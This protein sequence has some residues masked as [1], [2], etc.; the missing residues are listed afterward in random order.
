M[1]KK[2]YTI[3][4]DTNITAIQNNHQTSAMSANTPAKSYISCNGASPVHWACFNGDV[5]ALEMLLHSQ[6]DDE[7]RDSVGRTA[8]FYAAS[9]GHINCCALLMDHHDDWIDV[10]DRKGDTPLHVAA[11]Y[12]H[13]GVVKLL[14][15]SAAD[16]N[17]R[18]RTGYAPLHLTSDPGCVDLLLKFG[19]DAMAVDKKGRT[20]LF[21]A[22]AENRT[23]CTRMFCDRAHQHPRL[24]SLADHRGDTPLHAAACN[25]YLRLVT[26]LIGTAVNVGAKN[27]RGLTAVELARHNSHPECV[28][29]LEPQ[30][31]RL[32]PRAAHKPQTPKGA[33]AMRVVYEEKA[34]ME[35]HPHAG[36]GGTSERGGH[37][38]T[39][40][41]MQVT[42]Q[43][44][45]T[46]YDASLDPGLARLLAAV[47]TPGRAGIGDGDT[48]ASGG[49]VTA[50][51]PLARLAAAVSGGG[52]GGG[53]AASNTRTMVSP[54]KQ[55]WV[56]CHD[57]ASGHVFFKELYS[58]H[59]QWDPPHGNALV[60][61]E[62]RYDP[63]HATTG[64]DVWWNIQSGVRQEAAPT[65]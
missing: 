54:D 60:N 9:N 6:R 18:N 25:G 3:K 50:S 38:G 28:A 22:C 63:S 37:D 16:V 26:M 24:I 64:R 65:R 23:E 30:M 14:L 61:N 29:V 10:G 17:V 11:F 43:S 57:E 13:T 7:I 52:G 56:S 36:W 39:Q 21:C 53:A 19:A 42:A 27:V 31:A 40:G 4:A 20:P 1:I 2:F 44:E 35:I 55:H 8:L 47:S 46:G 51:D 34:P 32:D 45:R 59:T 12:Q 33:A 49:G 15:E 5:G 62:W 48:N 58:A 41:S